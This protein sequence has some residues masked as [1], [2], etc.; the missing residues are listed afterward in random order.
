MSWLIWTVYGYVTAADV[1]DG[2]R[3]GPTGVEV[4]VDGAVGV[5]TVGVAETCAVIELVG[6]AICVGAASGLPWFCKSVMTEAAALMTP[7]TTPTQKPTRRFPEP[8]FFEPFGCIL[9]PLL[10]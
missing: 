2:G 10:W 6:V 8:S 7:A 3:G 5:A 1:V 4:T 9:N